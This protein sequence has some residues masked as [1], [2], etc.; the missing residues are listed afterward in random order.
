VLSLLIQ[1]IPWYGMKVCES[2]LVS[3]DDT[4]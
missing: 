1:A 3:H 4:F 2:Q